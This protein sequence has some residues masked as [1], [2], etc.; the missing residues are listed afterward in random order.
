[1]SARL[2]RS[3]FICR[4][5]ASTRSAGGTMSL[6]S[7]RLTLSPHGETAAST[8][9]N[10]RSLISSRC[11]SNRSRSIAP[12]T[13]RI[14]VMNGGLFERSDLIARLGGIDDL[15]EDYAVHR[16][17]RVVLGDDVLLRHVDHLLHDI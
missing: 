13:E 10:S 8:T 17:G 11:D 3:A 15:E 4:P 16:N 12:I 5:M 9:R 1:M 2:T 14:L 6:I 7:M